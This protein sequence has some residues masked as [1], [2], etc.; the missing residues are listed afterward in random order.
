M[1]RDWPAVTERVADG[2]W[3]IEFATVPPPAGHRRV[4]QPVFATNLGDG[5]ERFL[6]RVI[7]TRDGRVTVE[8]SEEYI[9][10]SEAA[11]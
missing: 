4:L 3:D 7:V 8:Y 11:P 2:A 6:R 9:E 1:K 10:Y 5:V